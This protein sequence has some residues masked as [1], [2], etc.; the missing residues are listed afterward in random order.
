MSRRDPSPRRR[1]RRSLLLL[2]V[3][4]SVLGGAGTLPARAQTTAETGDTHDARSATMIAS[5]VLK[6]GPGYLPGAGLSSHL[7]TLP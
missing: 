3:M 4:A 5:F 2:A 6:L 7:R 1:A